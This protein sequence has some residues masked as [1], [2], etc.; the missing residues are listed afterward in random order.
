MKWTVGLDTQGVAKLKLSGELTLDSATELKEALKQALKA[1]PEII[2]ELDSNAEADLSCLQ[3]FCAAHQTAL[4]QGLKL[5]L[6]PEHHQQFQE[7]TC[8]AGL[9]RE[10]KCAI[11]PEMACLL[12]RGYQ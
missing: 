10:K 3:L 4:S 6:I 1:A 2:I 11:H 7:L 12:A 5:S 9:C 8:S